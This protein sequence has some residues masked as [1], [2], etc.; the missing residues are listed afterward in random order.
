[1]HRG[2]GLQIGPAHI[3]HTVAIEPVDIDAGNERALVGLHRLSFHNRGQIEQVAPAETAAAAE[4]SPLLPTRFSKL[5]RKEA[6][7]KSGVLALTGKR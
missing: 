2:V 7:I 1:M 4:I 6:R 3:C 5:L